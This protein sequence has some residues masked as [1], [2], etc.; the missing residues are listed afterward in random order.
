[1]NDIK[2]H[3]GFINTPY[4]NETSTAPMRSSKLEERRKRKRGFSRTMTA[5]KLANILE[6]KYNIVTVFNE[7]HE[8]DIKKLIE[9]G[10]KEVAE[11][12]IATRK[13]GETTHQMKNLMKPYTTQIE[14]MF[15][16]FLDNEEMNGLVEGVPTAVSVTGRRGRRPG[17][18]FIR[19]GI[20]KAS[21]RAWVE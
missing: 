11:H 8:E 3:M 21:F 1:M 10:F 14:R 15:R 17:P 16:N 9:N 7:V 18:S 2:L 5:E 6:N 13:T 19:T 4:T 20:Y 12:M